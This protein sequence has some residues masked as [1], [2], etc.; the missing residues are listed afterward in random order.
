MLSLLHRATRLLL[1]LSLLTGLLYPLAVTGLARA[2]LPDQAA[3]SLIR[4][5]GREVGSAL[6]GQRF[7]S[8]RY[9]QGRPS[10]AGPEGYDALASG[11]SNLALSNPALRERRA[12]DE[13]RLST[14]NPDAPGS[15]PE[16]LLAASG[17]GLDPDLSPEAARWQAP[18]IATARGAQVAQILE[19]IDSNIDDNLLGPP[20]VNVLAVN[21]ALDQH[22]P[23]VGAP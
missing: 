11:G 23:A 4:I 15:V 9:L 5:E 20:T 13:A 12:R 10:A 16:I 18:R 6:I 21:L 1:A 3:G 8:A 2:L 14:D 22:L 17:S 7:S 19:I